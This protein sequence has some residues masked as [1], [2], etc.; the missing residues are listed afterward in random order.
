[1]NQ[2]NVPEVS[3]ETL[4]FHEDSSH[5]TPFSSLK[6]VGCSHSEIRIHPSSNRALT[7][8]LCSWEFWALKSSCYTNSLSFWVHLCALPVCC[9]PQK[10]LSDTSLQK[11]R[12]ICKCHMEFVRA[13]LMAPQTQPYPTLL[14]TLPIYSE[15]VEPGESQ[16]GY[17]WT[18]TQHQNIEGVFK[19]YLSL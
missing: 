17:S 2:S 4:Y 3:F 10:W 12:I 19:L 8:E 16:K 18:H 14:P 5:I 15:L 1:M 13:D 9:Q 7:L 11:S 6:F